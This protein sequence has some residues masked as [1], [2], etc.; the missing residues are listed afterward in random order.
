MK[1]S[2]VE[3]LNFSNHSNKLE[4]N[5]SN[6]ETLVLTGEQR[7]TLHCYDTFCLYFKENDIDV[8]QFSDTEFAN[9]AEI[10][11]DYVKGDL[12]NTMRFWID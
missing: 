9:A 12:Y 11:E 5:N 2:L 1:K 3:M 6:N 7:V 4:P 8:N 10:F